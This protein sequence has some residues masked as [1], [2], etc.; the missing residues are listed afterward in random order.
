MQFSHIDRIVRAYLRR[1]VKLLWEKEE[2]D[3]SMRSYV[4]A[5]SLANHFRIHSNIRFSQ[6][7]F[8]RLSLAY[9]YTMYADGISHWLKNVQA[10]TAS[11]RIFQSASAHS[12]CHLIR[13]IECIEASMHFFSPIRITVNRQVYK[14]ANVTSR[15]HIFFKPEIVNNNVIQNTRF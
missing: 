10:K 9:R 5:T 4:K 7:F 12:D 13:C 1:A 3:K 6:C 15:W 14:Q 8:N 11:V 2:V